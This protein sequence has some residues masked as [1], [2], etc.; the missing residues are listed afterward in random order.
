MPAHDIVERLTEA[1]ERLNDLSCNE[2]EAL[3]IESAE[4]IQFLRSLLEPL[5][6]AGLEDLPPKGSA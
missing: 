6:D 1:L 2:V 4:T 3:L 5:D